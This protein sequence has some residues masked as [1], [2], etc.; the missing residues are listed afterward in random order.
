MS[1]GPLVDRAAWLIG[2]ALVRLRFV[3]GLNAGSSR[4]AG[5]GVS[6]AMPERRDTKSIKAFLTKDC[7]ENQSVHSGM[8]R[9]ANLSEQPKGENEGNS[10]SRSG[11]RLD[12]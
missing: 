10:V 2:Q 12:L 11:R 3:T 6:I 1:F 8:D 5:T 4:L 9:I 7:G